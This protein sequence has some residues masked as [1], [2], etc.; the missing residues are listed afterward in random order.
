PARAVQGDLFDAGFATAAAAEAA[1]ARLLESIGGV[2]YEPD[3][4][5][6]P[7]AEKRTI[8]EPVPL[9]AVAER[10]VKEGDAVRSRATSHAARDAAAGS[11]RVSAPRDADAIA[12]DAFDG[13][14]DQLTLQLLAKPK[15]IQIET[16]RRRDHEAP[17]RYH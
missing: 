11:P 13:R 8:L 2:V 1:V 16:E 15:P 5:A 9:A 7:L 3:A 4:N 17:V 12:T 6:H 10:R 14:P